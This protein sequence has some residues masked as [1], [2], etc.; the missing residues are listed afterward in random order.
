MHLTISPADM[1][2]I[3]RTAFSAG[4]PSILLMEQAAQAVVCTLEDML[5]GCDDR[6]VLFVAGCGNNGGDALAAARMFVKMG[7]EATVWLPLGCKTPDAQSNLSYLKLLSR[8]TLVEGEMPAGQ[9]LIDAVVDGLLG[10]GLK[11]TPEGAALSAIEYINAQTVPVLSIDV[12]SGMDALTGHLTD[13]ACVHADCTVT[14]HR[15]KTGLYLTRRRA[16]V[17]QI[18]LA[19]IGLPQ[20]CDDAPGYLV[21]EESDLVDL[22]PL[23][24]TDMHKGACGRV[25]LYA[26]SMGMSGAAAMAGLASLRAGAGLATVICPKEVMPILQ[27]QLPN[28]MCVDRD[29]LP[30]FVPLHD[31]FVF[32][33]G[34]IEDDHA[35]QHILSLHNENTPSVWD[36]GALNLLSRH[37]MQL[38]ENAVLTPHAAEAARLLS[39]TLSEVLADPVAAAKAIV[40]KYACGAVALKSA[41]TVVTDGKRV[42]LNVIGTSALAK[43]GSGDALAGILGT[44]LAGGMPP[45][46]AAQGACLWHGMAGR[47]AE[48]QFGTR[49]VL[50]G[51]VAD[52]L[53][54]CLMDMENL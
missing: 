8:V 49:G 42:S 35:W 33:C 50:T 10:T 37:P 11:Q 20:D 52:A 36:A 28:A 9:L 39:C 51:N 54:K 46:E 45:F 30:E 4:V 53:G 44:L 19:D 27:T 43:G 16:C 14:F 47:E 25:V 29:R 7:G 31:A 32:G 21:P 38:G 15:V 23:R 2:R 34:I 40:R 18:V 17:G 26:G 6:H 13:N 5:D 3:E 41:T 12:P 1:Q 24:T 22:V 48:R